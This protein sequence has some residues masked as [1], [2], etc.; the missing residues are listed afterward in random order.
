MVRS[1]NPAGRS[2]SLKTKAV[3]MNNVTQVNGFDRVVA[4]IIGDRINKGKAHDWYRAGEPANMETSYAVIMMMMR[5]GDSL[6]VDSKLKEVIAEYVIKAGIPEDVRSGYSPYSSCLMI[7]QD[8][9]ICTFTSHSWGGRNAL[10]A[11]VPEY[12]MRGQKAYPVV[13]LSSVAKNNQFGTIDPVFRV[14]S[15]APAEK[16]AAITG[17]LTESLVIAAPAPK[18]EPAAKQTSADIID[19]IIPF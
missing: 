15:W 2:R 9:L 11:L 12:R 14:L 17:D 19:D 16:F 3:N 6:W 13:Q 4:D 10:I 5:M 8:G 7:D 1:H 18:A